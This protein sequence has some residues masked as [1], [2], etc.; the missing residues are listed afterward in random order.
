LL[1][2]ETVLMLLGVLTGVVAPVVGVA[3]YVNN[4]WCRLSVEFDKQ[5][6]THRLTSSQRFV[7]APG[8]A[9]PID[10]TMFRL[11]FAVH[12]KSKKGTTIPYNMKFGLMVSGCSLGGRI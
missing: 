9:P 6:C 8:P 3:W 12:C 2:V 10:S 5:L 4:M 7:F 11:K 1:Q